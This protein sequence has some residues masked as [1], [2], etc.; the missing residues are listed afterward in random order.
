MIFE[1]WSSLFLIV[2]AVIDFKTKKVYQSICLINY[3]LAVGIKFFI[4]DMEPMKLV[5]GI[6]LCG[7]LF[8]IS[9]ITKEAI[10]K[11]DVLII[12]TLTGILNVIKTLEILFVALFICSVFSVA[13]L[14]TKKMKRKDTIPF[15]P[16]LLAGYCVWI[17]SGGK[18]V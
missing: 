10:G 15:V 1:I 12:L 16:F 11:G 5:T 14:I 6:I 2:C 13:M 9:V 8:S 3:G 4:H 7:I 17:I 18:Y